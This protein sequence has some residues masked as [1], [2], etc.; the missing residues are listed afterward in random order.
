LIDESP[1]SQ[2]VK[3]I[4]LYSRSNVKIV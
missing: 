2:A 3:I 4:A 1:V